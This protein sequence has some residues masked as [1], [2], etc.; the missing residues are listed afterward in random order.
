MKKNDWLLAAAV[1]SYS[2]LFY[3]QFAGINFLCFTLVFTG[4]LI[5]RNGRFML[6]K[7]TWLPLAGAVISAVCIMI[8]GKD[9]AVFANIFSLSI[10]AIR[11]AD[12]S[13][14]VLAAAVHA[15]F[16]Y[17]SVPVRLCMDA[18]NRL[19]NPAN[20]EEAGEEPGQAKRSSFLLY[21]IPVLVFLLFVL[22]YRGSS[23][24][25]R[26][27]TDQLSFDI[28]SLQ[29]IFF[30]LGGFI[31]LYAVYYAKRISALSELEKKQSQQI[32]ASGIS[33]FR[34][35]GY[36]VTLDAEQRSGMIM[37]GLLNLLILVVNLLD[38]QFLLL[39]GVLP[40]GM[41]YAE[42]V[43]QGIGSLIFSIITAIAIILWYFRGEQNFVKSNMLKVLAFIWIMQNVMM[44][45]SNVYK[46]SLYIEEF[47]LTYKR[48]GVY[49][50]LLLALI[51][52]VSA[53]V[54][55]IRL[56][57]GWFLLRVNSVAAYMVLLAACTVNWDLL[58]TRFNINQAAHKAQSPDLQYIASLS[59]SVIPDLYAWKQQHADQFPDH[60]REQ[61]DEQLF[62]IIETRSLV[63]W[64][65]WSMERSRISNSI[66][67]MFAE[68]VID[69]VIMY[70]DK[71]AVPSPEK[72]KSVTIHNA[73]NNL[74]LMSDLQRFSGV[75]SLD[76]SQNHLASVQGFPVLPALQTLNVNNNMITDMAPL[77]SNHS[78]TE[79]NLSFNDLRN[80]PDLSGL[81]NLKQLDLSYN[82]LTSILPLRELTGLEHLNL[83]NNSMITDLTP[84]HQLTSLKTLRINQVDKA[85]T[86]ALLRALPQLQIT[87]Y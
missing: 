23:S 72:L 15:M 10:L 20:V 75:S 26:N 13:G 62:T 65:S 37:L 59:A 70:D 27:L 78:I 47:S 60:V 53:A 22:L 79:L 6:H 4:I 77:C 76:I 2:Y 49:V 50:Y 46:N 82:N 86:D 7:H 42:L 33:S 67:R 56:R 45:V 52:L 11:F 35:F 34:M 18:V 87:A 5:S 64:R 48:I 14:S 63:D 68:G 73:F 17:I 66:D 85:Q 12:T 61:L 84:L 54:K 1:F 25:F 8:Y 57:T 69:S 58:I 40:E 31:L 24:L 43:H 81:A 41:G 16:S 38:V 74:L 51:G 71:I 44:I 3:E 80:L 30:T 55:I 39:G 28:I 29:R 83:Y 19:Y 32:S 21:V 36:T 9:L